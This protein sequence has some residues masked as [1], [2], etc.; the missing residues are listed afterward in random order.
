MARG[1]M[2]EALRIAMSAGHSVAAL[3]LQAFLLFIAGRLREGEGLLRRAIAMAP[4]APD[5][6]QMLIGILCAGGSAEGYRTAEEHLRALLALAPGDADAWLALGIARHLQEAASSSERL[7]DRAK[8]LDPAKPSVHAEAA[9]I[10]LQHGRHAEMMGAARAACVLAPDMAK[11]LHCLAEG[12]HLGGPGSGLVWFD[13]LVRLAPDDPVSQAVRARARMVDGDWRAGFADFEARRDLPI[14]AGLALASRAPSWAGQD[15]AGKVVLVQSEQGLGDVLQ[16]LRF[17][18]PLAAIARAVVLAVKP[19]LLPLLAEFG[20]SLPRVTVIPEAGMPQ[21]TADVAIPIMSLP[22]AL[23][24]Y[25]EADAPGQA[26][27][28][29]LPRQLDRWAQATATMQGLK[30]GV[31]WAGNPRPGS[32]P[33]E[34]LIDRRRSIGLTELAPLFGLEGI[35]W[36]SLQHEYRAGDAPGDHG[37]LDASAYLNDFSDLAG[38]IAN[39]D[40]VVSVDTAVAHLAGALGRPVW[41]INRFDTCWRWQRTGATTPWYDSMTIF[42]QTAPGD[43]AGVL[44]Q[45]A[46]RL[47]AVVA[48]GP[49][50]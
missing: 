37:V 18:R 26:Y 50:Q 4:Q 16:F 48:R 30:V 38:L 33:D 23:R 21:G 2:A 29:P 5:L 41:L 46:A 40:L 3:R 28:S 8:M 1:D 13:R 47:A 17:I 35:C 42:R 20:R 12:I 34:N 19:P 7:V 9:S 11:A 22:H 32:P 6:R 44:Q 39:L 14:L 27:L 15:L 24:L 45:A 49:D 10:L 36:V 43:W 31:C 25:P